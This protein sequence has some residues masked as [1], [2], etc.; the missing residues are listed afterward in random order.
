MGQP[1]WKV[2]LTREV[3]I[4]AVAY[5][6]R[7]L[8]E[9]EFVHQDSEQRGLWELDTPENSQVN[10]RQEMTLKGTSKGRAALARQQPSDTLLKQGATSEI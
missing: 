9:Q 4:S 2:S 5:G 3:S 7:S 8:E 1:T 6:S 10:V